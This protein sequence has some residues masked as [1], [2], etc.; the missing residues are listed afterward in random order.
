MLRKTIKNLNALIDKAKVVKDNNGAL[1][2]NF[3]ELMERIAKKLNKIQQ[4]LVLKQADG[5]CRPA[6]IKNMPTETELGHHIHLQCGHNGFMNKVERNK[7]EQHLSAA[8]FI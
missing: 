3:I 2:L 1:F 7:L 8:G 5:D 6:F 4:Q